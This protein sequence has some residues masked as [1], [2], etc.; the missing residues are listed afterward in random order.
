MKIQKSL[1]FLSFVIIFGIF[2]ADITYW[3]EYK[4]MIDEC[5]DANKAW[6]NKS[7]DDF[8]CRVW[9][10]EEIAYQVVLD[11]EFIVLDDEMD[12]YIENLEN[13]KSYYF[14]INRKKTFIDWINDIE[15]KRKY[16]KDWYLT[17]CW[18]TIISKVMSCMEDEKVST[19]NTKN[20]FKTSWCEQL[21]NKKLDIFSDVTFAV[22][23]LNKEQV[24]SDQKKIYDQ[25]ER[26]NY[27]MVLD[28]MMINLWYLERIWKKWPVKLANPI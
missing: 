3:C 19:S 14:W 9:N 28:I 13:N 8:V 5:M 6:V 23:M 25:L 16:F 4:S 26:R 21:V 18:E 17:L 1:I 7:I 10:Y 27:D 15:T 22:L 12:L 20:F 2:S 24:N 11:Q